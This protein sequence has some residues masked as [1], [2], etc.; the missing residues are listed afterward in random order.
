MFA[1]QCCSSVDR[2]GNTEGEYWHVCQLTEFLYY[3]QILFPNSIYVWMTLAV[4]IICQVNLTRSLWYTMMYVHDESIRSFK[5]AERHRVEITTYG[6]WDHRHE[7]R[8]KI[9]V[10]KRGVNNRGMLVC[11]KPGLRITS[12]SRRLI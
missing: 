4:S 9:K 5:I 2:R 7:Q 11:N 1:N 12:L 6:Q 3:A 10:M 8:C